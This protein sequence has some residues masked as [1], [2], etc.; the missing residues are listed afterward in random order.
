[1][2]RLKAD[3][4]LIFAAFIWG[5]AF[6]AQKTGM[7]GLGPISF[8]GVRFCISFL[9]VLPFALREYRRHAFA[10]KQNAWL[11]LGIAVSLFVGM[12]AQQIGLMTTTVTNAGFITGL[13]VVF[14]PFVALLALKSSIR[15]MVWV[16]SALAFTGIWFL[17][18]A[19]LSALNQG[20][21]IVMISALAFAVYI[22]LL[23]Q[24]MMKSRAPMVVTAS[25]YLFCALL[26]TA[27]GIGVEGIAPNAIWDNI[28]SLLYVG[29]LSGGLA[30]TI[31]AVAQQYTPPAVAAVIFSSESLFAAMAG[32][33]VLGERIAPLGY[34]GCVMIL[35]AMLIVELKPKRVQQA[36]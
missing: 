23:G 33:I 17:S 24:L 8:V 14:T 5:T 27:L 29:V 20:D 16:A 28:E 13:Y 26:G 6:V 36:A 15:H 31:Q 32:A 35:T 21:W 7:D 34:I 3:L 1:M 25:A 12:T 18:G 30:F 4:L 22:V 19:S 11:L 10:F 2:T 9:C